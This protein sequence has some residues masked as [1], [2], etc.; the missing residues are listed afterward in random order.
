[1]KGIS[2]KLYIFF[3]TFVKKQIHKHIFAYNEGTIK[4]YNGLQT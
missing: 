2:K 4:R 1:M 3:F